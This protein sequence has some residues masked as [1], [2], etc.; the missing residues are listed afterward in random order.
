MLIIYECLT[1]LSFTFVNPSN[2]GTAETVTQ[3]RREG[4]VHITW[5]V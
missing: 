5:A 1:L 2:S 3:A 4:Q